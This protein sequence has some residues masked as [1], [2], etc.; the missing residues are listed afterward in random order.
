MLFNLA[1]PD[2]IQNMAAAG[3]HLL[4]SISGGKDSDA[5]TRQVVGWWRQQQFAGSVELLHCDVGRM[6]WDQTLPH[7]RALASELGL[8]LAVERH[9]KRDLIDGIWRRM[10]VR[11]DAP[12]FPSSAARWCTSDYKRAVADRYIRNRWQSDSQVIQ[13]IGYR[14]D[15]SAARAKKP[16]WVERKAASAVTLNRRVVDWHPIL[17]MSL[18]DVWATLGY[19]LGELA[20][21]QSDVRSYRQMVSNTL[22]DVLQYIHQRG[23]NAHPAY[24]LGN[25]RLSCALC[26]LGS[27]NDLVNGVWAKPKLA[28]ELAD[29][30][31]QSGFTFRQGLSIGELIEGELSHVAE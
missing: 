7:C 4:V 8:P 14:R 5:M 20:S 13:C 26:V 15:E 9:S 18:E 17:S 19:T 10:E 16:D 29:I 22:S 24:A 12:P 27:R 23:F 28:R 21:I 3:A 2:E 6:E 30:E 31:M 25:E 1:I 11:P